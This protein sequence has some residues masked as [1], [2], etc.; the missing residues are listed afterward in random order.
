MADCSASEELPK[1]CQSEGKEIWGDIPDSVFSDLAIPDTCPPK[2]EVKP[3]RK[4]DQVEEKNISKVTINLPNAFENGVADC[5][6]FQIYKDIPFHL[7]GCW[8]LFYDEDNAPAAWE[9]LKRLYLCEKLPRVIKICK[10]NHL[11]RQNP[12]IGIPLSVFCGPCTDED[13]CTSVGKRLVTLM[14]HK[15]QMCN[16]N[17][18]Q[19][20]YYK[21]TKKGPLFQGGPNF[22]KVPYGV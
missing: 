5:F 10:A 15:R 18:P 22:Y 7:R 16:G 1:V 3:L 9:K 17:F 19:F 2:S 4:Y 13:L 12:S 14:K 11:C 8:N 20:V 21:R 6:A